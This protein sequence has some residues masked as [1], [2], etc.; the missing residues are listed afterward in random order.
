LRQTNISYFTRTDETVGIPGR[1][2]YVRL[3]SAQSAI[4]LNNIAFQSWG[5]MTI[6][7]RM[8]TISSFEETLAY[9]QTGSFFYSL[10]AKKS[11]EGAVTLQ[12]KHN[13]SKNTTQITTFRLL[14]DQWNLLTVYNDNT[15]IRLSCNTINGLVSKK[16]N[17][18]TV[19]VD[20]GK[21]LFAANAPSTITIGTNGLPKTPVSMVASSTA[22]TYDVAWVHFFDYKIQQQDILREASANWIYTAFPRSPDVFD[23]VEP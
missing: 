4:Q 7:L 17:I 8:K 14:I 11:A 5:S 18:S 20:A 13:F 15:G 12:I 21:L 9:F 19:S 6:A 23:F 22:C 3:N 16:E 1:K 10:V 2:P